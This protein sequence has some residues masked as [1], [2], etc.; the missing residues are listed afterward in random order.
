[1]KEQ[2]KQRR[3][4]LELSQRQVAERA[5]LH[6][7]TVMLIEQGKSSPSVE[8]LEKM[9]GVLDGRMFIQWDDPDRPS[10]VS[11]TE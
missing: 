8:T 2:L 3:L 10:V 6:T 1:M 7:R 5:G 11:D 4:A 9:L